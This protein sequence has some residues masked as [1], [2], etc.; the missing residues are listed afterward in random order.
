MIKLL[1]KVLNQKNYEFYP[2][3]DVR[4]V[5]LE[6]TDRCNASC[7]QCARNKNGGPENPR[8]PLKE[9]NLEQFKRFFSSDEIQNLSR[10]YMCGNYGDPIV[11]KDTLAI[12]EF[13]RSQNPNMTLAMNTNASARK[14][15]WWT[16]LAQVYGA[17]GNV[18]FGID[19]L[20][21][22][23]HL[24]RRGTD[25]RKVIENAKAFID[26]GGEAIWEFIVFKHNEHQIDE[27]RKLSEDMGFKKFHL[28]KTG[29]FYSNTKNTIRTRLPV[30]DK[31]EEVE[32]H[33]EMPTSEQHLNNSL[34]KEQG[35]VREFGSMQN[36]LD[37]T[38]I[39]CKTRE[40][41]SIYISSEGLVFPCCWTANQLYIWYREPGTS[42]VEKILRANGG[43]AGLDLGQNSLKSI[44]NGASFSAIQKSWSC[45][46]V[47]SG[48]LSV[49]AKTCGT[50]FDQFKDQYE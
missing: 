11:A 33:I 3:S 14:P 45:Q 49:C 4:V 19:G 39:I 24:Y 16:K 41:K 20:E 38:S 50:S 37:Q 23:H 47:E 35:I 15:D 22:T 26:A 5:H 1:K 48:K 9:L 25:F 18:K 43:K 36:Y 10:L 2:A 12:F 7:P 31:N 13:L 32:Y 44:I 40:E 42:S 30:L 6:M 8:L 21:D 34:K 46:S 27:A 29:R 28:K 17:K